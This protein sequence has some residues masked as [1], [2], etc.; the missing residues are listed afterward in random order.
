MSRRGFWKQSASS[1]SSVRCRRLIRRR[2]ASRSLKVSTVPTVHHPAVCFK[3]ST[4]T[5]MGNQRRRDYQRLRCRRL[6][7]GVRHHRGGQFS[8]LRNFERAD[9]A[10]PTALIQAS[11]GNFYGTTSEGGTYRGGTM[12]EI[13]AQGELT[14][15]YDF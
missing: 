14:T 12:F 3:V 1:V 15:L 9:R 2:R 6:W 4:E 11:D 5:C 13:T 10:G 8:T 7:H